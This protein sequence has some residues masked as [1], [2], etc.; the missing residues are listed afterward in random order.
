MKLLIIADDF[1][2]ALDTGVQFAN[3]GITTKVVVGEE[4]DFG[5]VTE[6]VIVID[7]ETRHLSAKQAYDIVYGIS[8]RAVH[9][10]VS[11][12]YKKTDSALRGNIGAELSALLDASKEKQ[13][14]FLPAFPQMNRIVKGGELYI[15]GVYVT[16][17]PFGID[18]FEPVK[19]NAVSDIIAQQSDKS[20]Y[21]IYEEDDMA[22]D[23][24]GIVI[25]DADSVERLEAAGTKLQKSGCLHIMSGCAGFGAVLAGLLNITPDRKVGAPQL[26]KRLLVVCGS[27][28][29]ITVK[30]IQKAEEAGFAH[31]HLT[32]K[33]KLDSGFLESPDAAGMIEEII[34]LLN[35]NQFCII[36]SNDKGGN[37]ATLEYSKK[38]GM[39]IEEVRKKISGALG[40]ITGQI[41]TNPAL[42]TL[43]ITGGDTLLECMNY[44]GVNEL[45]PICELEKGVV[46]SK[47]TYN[48]CTRYVISKSGG[49]GESGL[50]VDIS[51]KIKER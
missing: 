47:F 25:F 34:G 48:N 15:D 19:Y 40:Y 13:L 49:F 23:M 9:S 27:V 29:P 10:G 20:C 2:G 6:S 16:K 8:E 38:L 4:I 5:K 51:E 28:N 33:Q 14:P 32:P 46:L 44:I 45:E 18:P 36:D 35:N 12:I 42:G 39:S 11:Y 7:T 24:E 26:D 1:T 17:S 21:N 37:E 50:L 41:F 22:S 43:F 31:Y 3:S 30:Q